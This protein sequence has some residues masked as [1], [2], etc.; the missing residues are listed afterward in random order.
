M[1]DDN[2]ELEI[3]VELVNTYWV[4]ADPQDSLTSVSAFQGTL[5][6]LGHG[7]LA[8]QLGAADLPRL[9]RLR[10]RLWPVFAASSTAQ[11]AAALNPLLSE[12]GAVPQLVEGPGGVWQLRVGGGLRGV[13]ALQAMLAGALGAQVAAQGTN[14][15]GVCHAPPCQCVYVDRTRPGTRLFCCDQC[16][17]RAAAAAYRRRRRG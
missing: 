13:D 11:A 5:R 2:D 3:A 8:R 1:T 17:D 16:N 9:R 10:E 4:L 7:D 6:G 12:V 15:L 14:R